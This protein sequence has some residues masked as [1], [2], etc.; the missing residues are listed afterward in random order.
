MGAVKYIGQKSI[1]MIIYTCNLKI[2]ISPKIMSEQLTAQ[3]NNPEFQMDPN[4]TSF[5]ASLAS[6]YL[7]IQ[8]QHEQA[9][10]FVEPGQAQELGYTAVNQY[11]E[12]VPDTSPS[13]GSEKGEPNN[14]YERLSMDKLWEL[15]SSLLDSIAGHIKS[16]SPQEILE[17]TKNL[18]NVIHEQEKRD[19]TLPQSSQAKIVDGVGIF[20]EPNFE[21]LQD[22]ADALDGLDGMQSHSLY[23]VDKLG[24]SLVSTVDKQPSEEDMLALDFVNRLSQVL[25]GARNKEGT[26]AS[27]GDYAKDDH[28]LEDIKNRF[29][30]QL[31]NPKST[32]NQDLARTRLAEINAVLSL[33]HSKGESAGVKPRTGM[34]EL[35]RNTRRDEVFERFSGNMISYWRNQSASSKE[36]DRG[37]YSDLIKQQVMKVK[38]R[39]SAAERRALSY[40]N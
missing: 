37:V 34:D 5:E 19:Q 16:R 14:P 20:D 18:F 15:R 13:S 17:S 23:I 35:Q 28:E 4:F 22:I 32:T 40:G 3:A 27:S 9:E 11:V 8:Q 30:E 12:V 10:I 33:R 6:Q 29:Q 21:D 25:I 2:I 38:A 39:R 36:Q 26:P 24:K 31:D 7:D 1:S